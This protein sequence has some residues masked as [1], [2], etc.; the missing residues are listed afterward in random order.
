MKAQSIHRTT[1]N[2]FT[3]CSHRTASGRQ[4][5]QLSRDSHSGLCAHHR[6]LQKQKETDDLSHDLLARCQNFQTAQGVNFALANIYRLL[7]INRISPRRA[8]VLA[9]INSLLL[10]TLPAIDYDH[11]NGHTDPTTP[12]PNETEADEIEGDFSEP[13][14]VEVST[15]YAPPSHPSAS[16]AVW[17]PSDPEPDPAKKPS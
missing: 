10:R 9:Y 13:I 4:C 12:E 1:V 2:E 3:R 5:R 15:T 8:S 11:E 14:D 16:G 6:D 17:S 7:A